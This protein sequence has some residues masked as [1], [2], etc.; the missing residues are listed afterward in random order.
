[1]D[2][3]GEEAQLAETQALGAAGGAGQAEPAAEAAEESSKKQRAPPQPP[4]HKGPEKESGSGSSDTAARER[5]T[6]LA[7]Q[8]PVTTME[9]AIQLVVEQEQVGASPYVRDL[10]G[11]RDLCLSGGHRARNPAP[12]GSRGHSGSPGFRHRAAAAAPPPP[13]RASLKPTCRLELRRRPTP[14]TTPP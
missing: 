4:S 7:G 3:H 10:A 8:V 1:M 2:P 11:A 9:R 14:A 6:G 13:L 5:T 12:R